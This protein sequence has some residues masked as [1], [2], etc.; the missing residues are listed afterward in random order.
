MKGAE[1]ERLW[2]DPAGEDAI[3]QVY[4]AAQSNDGCPIR[5]LLDCAGQAFSGCPKIPNT[6]LEN[7]KS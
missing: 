7:C 6:G 4:T 5:L 1:M 2:N 3:S